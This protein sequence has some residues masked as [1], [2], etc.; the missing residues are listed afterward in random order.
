MPLL[1]DFQRELDCYRRLSQCMKLTK[2]KVKIFEI[3]YFHISI[4]FH[5]SSIYLNLYF[6]YHLA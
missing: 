4:W 1:D 3:F 5:F 6:V 2:Q